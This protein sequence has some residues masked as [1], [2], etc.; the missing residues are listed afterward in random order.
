MKLEILVVYVGYSFDLIICVVVVLIYQIIFYVFDDIQYGVDLFDLKVLGNI[1]IWIMN[2]INDVLEQCVVVLEG[3]VG[4]LVVVLGMVVII[5]VIQIVVEV[6]DNIVLVVKFY[7]GIYNLLVYILLCIGIQVCF[8]VYDDIVVLE[9]LIDEWIK[10]VFCEIIGNLVG[11]IIDLQV[12]VDVVYCYGVLL[13]VDNMVVIL[14]FCWLFEYGVDIIVYLLIKYMG[15]YG[16]SIGGIVVD[17]G[18]FDWVVNKLCFLL[19]NM[20]DL[21]YYGVIYIEVFG[22]VVFIGCCWVV[23]LCNMG[24]VFLLFNVFFI[25]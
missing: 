14:V 25:F 11:N 21:F 5:Y 16:I 24:V 9:V 15:G 22:F 20:F 12:L 17:F 3:G 4:V 8:V 23:L 19:L 6:G 1:Y 7:G 18:K 10:V 13:I 2:F